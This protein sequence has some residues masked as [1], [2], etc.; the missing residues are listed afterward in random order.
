MAD[1]GFGEPDYGDA[2]GPK[3]WGGPQG[4]MAKP[5]EAAPLHGDVPA[6]RMDMNS[7]GAGRSDLGYDLGAKRGYHTAGIGGSANPNALGKKGDPGTERSSASGG[8]GSY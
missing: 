1:T 3:G 2:I 5:Y 4:G 8:G 6:A 7:L